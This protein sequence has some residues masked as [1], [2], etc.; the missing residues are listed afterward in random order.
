[1]STI[2]LSGRHLSLRFGHRVVLDDIN[3]D[4][5]RGE[6]TALLGPNGAGKSTLL[7][8]LSGE[9][10]SDNDIRYFGIPRQQ[11]SLN[12]LAKHLGMLPQ[13]STLS[14]PFL[15]HEVVELGAIPLEQPQK[16]VAALA[17][18]KMKVTDVSHLATRPYPALSGGEK[19]RLHLARVLVQLAHS[20][21][22]TILMLDEPT[23]ALDLAHQ[24][25][26][27]RIARQLAQHSN[28]AVV[29]VLHDLNLA[30]QFADR[31]VM[32]H[33]GKIV[34]DAAPKQ[35]LTPELLKQ[36]YNYDALVTT[37]PTLHFPLV[38]PAN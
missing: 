13:H 24:Q 37:H 25:N 21:E 6:V 18:E 38:Q 7:K 9:I 34:C 8:L 30:A 11:W 22:E 26:T 4:I 10:P 5:H 35:A 16:V 31:M 29:V 2:A 15:A 33:Q 27:L 19:Q 12:K 23:S 32:L 14:F 3:I 20:G 1:M 36:V 28:A 17:Q